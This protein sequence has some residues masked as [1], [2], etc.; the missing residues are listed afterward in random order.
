MKHTATPWKSNGTKVLTDAVS[1]AQCRTALI[2]SH[3]QQTAN[4]AFIVR[5]CN[6]HD[7]LLSALKLALPIC[8]D[9]ARASLGHE[10][11]LAAIQDALSEAEGRS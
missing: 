1:I 10:V 5:A 4:A 6:A 8:Q 9:A 2:L 11:T 7:G 3:E